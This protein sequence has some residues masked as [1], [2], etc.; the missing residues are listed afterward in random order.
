[1]PSSK[2]PSSSKSSM[3]RKSFM[4]G[5]ITAFAEC[6]AGEA[7]KMAFSPPF[8]REDYKSLC[9]EAEKICQEQGIFVWHEENEDLPEGS[10]LQWLVL[11]KFPEVLKEYKKLRKK[12]FNPALHFEKFL[13]LLSY[14]SAWG[15]NAGKV[16]P[17]MREKRPVLDTVAR[18]LLK[19]GDW[20]IKSGARPAT[21]PQE[22]RARRPADKRAGR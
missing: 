22:R 13:V 14:G 11:F 3:D 12:G 20:P 16:V 15:R 6:I 10:R 9:R 2:R 18:V 17:R 19:P 1:M 4:L 21:P 5:M 7:K 8:Y